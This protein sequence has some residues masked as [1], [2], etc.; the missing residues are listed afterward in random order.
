[1]KPVL[2]AGGKYQL[3]RVGR[4][5]GCVKRRFRYTLTEL[6]FWLGFQVSTRSKTVYF[7]S[8]DLVYKFLLSNLTRIAH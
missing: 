7:T 1:M 5:V 6:A 8:A 2:H 3:E 4:G